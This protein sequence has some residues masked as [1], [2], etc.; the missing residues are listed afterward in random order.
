MRKLN[1]RKVQLLAQSQTVAEPGFEPLT[2]VFL[3][4]TILL[5]TWWPQH[6]VCPADT[7]PIH[8]LRS[9]PQ[10][11]TVEAVESPESLAAVAYL[12]NLVLKR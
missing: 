8:P 2:P 9:G 1:P 3:V 7:L 6:P 10:M 11:T 5:G 4:T 12:L